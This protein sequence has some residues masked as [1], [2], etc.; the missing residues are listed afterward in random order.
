MR[1]GL[2]LSSPGWMVVVL[3]GHDVTIPVA[4]E[5]SEDWGTIREEGTWRCLSLLHMRVSPLGKSLSLVV[6]Y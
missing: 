2:I 3:E 4:G 5:T 1:G 6:K